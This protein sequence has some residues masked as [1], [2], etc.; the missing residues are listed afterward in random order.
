MSVVGGRFLGYYWYYK[1]YLSENWLMIRVEPFLTWPAAQK[2]DT[3][4]RGF[5]QCGHES[6]TIPHKQ[7]P[8][9]YLVCLESHG[10]HRSDFLVVF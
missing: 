2:D 9:G 10:K 6:L 1:S 7:I 8:H 5:F 4:R 3:F